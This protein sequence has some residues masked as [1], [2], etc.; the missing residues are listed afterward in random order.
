MKKQSQLISHQS[1]RK[2]TLHSVVDIVDNT[3][4]VE[5]ANDVVDCFYTVFAER[6]DVEKL[7]VEF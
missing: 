6:K 2:A 5:S 3:V 1:C 7:E 4:V